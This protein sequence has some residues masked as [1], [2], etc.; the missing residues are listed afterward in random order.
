MLNKILNI[1]KQEVGTT[2]FPAG[3]NNVKYNTWYYGKKV[4]GDEYPWCM[5]FC[6]WVMNEAGASHLFYGGKKTASCGELKKYAINHNQWVA[7]NYEVGDLVMMSFNGK[8]HPQ[9]V[10]FITAV[11]GNTIYT[12]E[13]NTSFDDK[14]SQSNGGA[15]AE[16]Q[17]SLSVIVGAYR[18]DYDSTNTEKKKNVGRTV[19]ATAKELKKGHCGSPVKVLQSAL[20]TLQNSNLEVDGEF[21]AATESALIKYQQSHRKQCGNENGTCGK[22][23]WI[24]I[25]S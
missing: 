2:E 1:L 17:R 6:C 18:P 14:G 9:H 22:K 21:G 5:A 25:L 4:S 11:K 12:I 3:S 23:T 8:A 7:S 16:K 20:N 13:G 19:M 24:S 15:V 10:G